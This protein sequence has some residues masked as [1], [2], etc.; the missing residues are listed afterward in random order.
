MVHQVWIGKSTYKFFNI[1]S[2]QIPVIAPC[3]SVKRRGKYV[4]TGEVELQGGELLRRLE[5]IPEDN[6]EDIK[7]LF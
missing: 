3:K 1:Q 6:S 4:S 2:R 7:E 5:E